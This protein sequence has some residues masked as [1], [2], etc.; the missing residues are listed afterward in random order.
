MLSVSSVVNHFLP[1]QNL[2]ENQRRDDGGVGF[3][4]EFRSLFAEFAPS[5]FFIGD[6]AGVAAV[7]G[8]RIAD[9][10]EVGPE[11]DIGLAE[12]LMEHGDDADGEVAGDAAADL[13]EPDGGFETGGGI[14][15]GEGDHVFDA[16][17]DGVDIFHISFDAVASIHVAERGVL[18]AGD[19]HGEIF[20]LRGD[21]PAVFRIDLETFLEFGRV[22]DA[23]E[24]FVREKA[25]PLGVGVHPL[26]E[27]DIFDAAHGFH[28]GNAGVGDA[29]HVALEEGLLIGRGEV[30][31]VRDAF[32]EIVG[33]EIEDV[34][35]EVGAG[36]DDAVDFS[37]A[38]HFSEGNAQLGRAHGASE[39]HEHDAALIEV[40][41]VGFRGVFECGGIEVAVVEIDEL[42]NGTG[43]HDEEC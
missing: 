4:D 6:G 17:A 24:K 12:V 11:G 21:H 40:A 36:A 38:D 8:S 2:C 41:R 22:K 1:T 18:P 29:V 20:F 27:D 35:F 14:P 28:F 33:D 13:E 9:L 7:A 26:F 25:L 39:G 43:L 31:V 37:L 34:F 32:V 19:E 23:P 10:A 42:R 30:A 15:V 5:D 3:D 16:G